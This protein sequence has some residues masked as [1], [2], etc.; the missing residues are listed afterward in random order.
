MNN[1]DDGSELK[2]QNER[3][4]GDLLTVA[5]RVSHDLR[6]PLGGILSAADALRELCEEP[7]ANRAL[8]DSLIASA[9]ELSKMIKDISFVLKATTSPQP[10]ELLK[11]EGVFAFALQRLERRIVSA[12]AVI[13]QP[14]SW[15]QAN[16]VAQ[17]LET[18]WSTLLGFALQ[19]GGDSP[20][21]EVG[22]REGEGE[23]I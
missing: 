2:N 17:W 19:R 1:S 5:T 12:G 18:I 3:L 11:M 15:P 22:W 14:P 10:K 23:K 16:G 6:T 13:V 8:V 4:R 7:S 20:K 21:I 9:E